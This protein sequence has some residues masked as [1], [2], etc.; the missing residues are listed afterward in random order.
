MVA[1]C[2]CIFVKQLH[3]D[4]VFWAAAKAGISDQSPAAW[5]Q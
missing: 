2:D 5:M 1:S 4:P 3:P